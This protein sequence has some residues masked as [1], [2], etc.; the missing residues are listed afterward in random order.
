MA[1]FKI[2]TGEK[3]EYEYNGHKIV[4]L[5]SPSKTAL[6]VDGKMQDKQNGFALSCTLNGKVDGKPIKVSLGGFWNVECDV[7]VDHEKLELVR[8]SEC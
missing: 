8:K 6:E 7:F 5:N 1:R 3:W 2:T 4:V